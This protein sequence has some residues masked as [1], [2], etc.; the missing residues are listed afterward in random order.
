M[1]IA[2]LLFST[3]NVKA[4]EW[5]NTDKSITVTTD[6]TGIKGEST[7]FYAQWSENGIGI[8]IDMKG[9]KQDALNKYAE[10]PK[11]VTAT[12]KLKLP[13]NITKVELYEKEQVYNEEINEWEE[14]ERN[15]NQLSIETIGGNKYV[16]FDRALSYCNQ[17]GFT[18]IK[19]DIQKILMRSDYAVSNNSSN[20]WDNFSTYIRLFSSDSQYSDYLIGAQMTIISE[21]ESYFLEYDI[22]NK[23]G[24]SY[25]KGRLGIWRPIR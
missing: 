23:Y 7:E 8:D 10:S 20:V 2:I 6:N 1:L 14:K 22:V 12:I 24:K 3:S 9:V 17:S 4:V 11:K 18:P 19:N 16:I 15:R 13:S 25:Q 21:N 5:S